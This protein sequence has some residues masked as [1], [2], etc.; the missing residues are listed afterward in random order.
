[1]VI[2]IQWQGCTNTCTVRHNIVPALLSHAAFYLHSVRFLEFLTNIGFFCIHSERYFTKLVNSRQAGL[3]CLV[4]K[5][6]SCNLLKQMVF[7]Q[8]L[9]NKVLSVQASVI[10]LVLTRS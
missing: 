6:V 10:I 5:F 4:S 8:P 3:G 7:Q 9:L 1:M 2:R